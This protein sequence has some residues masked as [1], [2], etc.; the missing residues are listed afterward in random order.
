MEK[1]SG[2]SLEVVDSKYIFPGLASQLPPRT[3]G[4]WG[5]EVAHPAEIKLIPKEER[6]QALGGGGAGQPPTIRPG[7]GEGFRGRLPS[8]RGEG[9]YRQ[10]LRRPPPDAV[11]PGSDQ[12][13]GNGLF[14]KKTVLARDEATNNKSVD[15]AAQVPPYYLLRYF[16]FDVEPGKQYTYRVFPLLQNPNNGLPESALFDP[17]QSSQSTLS[18]TPG[19]DQPDAKNQVADLKIDDKGWS[20]ACQSTRLPSDNRLIAGTVEPA[21]SPS[22]AEIT[23]QVRIIIWDKDTGANKWTEKATIFRGTPIDSTFEGATWHPKSED[24]T[25]PEPKAET[26]SILVDVTGGGEYLSPR[27][28]EK[29]P[30]PPGAMLVLSDNGELVI[31]DEMGESKDWND[32]TKEPDR[33]SAGGGEGRRFNPR[34]GG[35]RGSSPPRGRPSPRPDPSLPDSAPPGH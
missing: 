29:S 5:D 25:T 20:N 2:G 4:E 19:K 22:P 14:G 17:K 31:H 28:R 11:R 3:T 33:P 16:D 1:W 24:S 23:G 26:N 10:N 34:G 9:A 32:A 35:E 15:E 30:H 8:G 13:G 27:D 6:D 21:K 12:G 18:V 7:A